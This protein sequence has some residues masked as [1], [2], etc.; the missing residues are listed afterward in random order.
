MSEIILSSQV[1]VSV[2]HDSV[3]KS[4]SYGWHYIGVGKKSWKLRLFNFED[5]EGLRPPKHP[6]KI[7]RVR[8]IAQ[9][10]IRQVWVE[11]GTHGLW[12]VDEYFFF[13]D[14]QSRRLIRIKPY[15]PII[16]NESVLPPHALG[17][18]PDLLSKTITLNNLRAH[19]RLWD[20]QVIFL[21]KLSGSKI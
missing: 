21:E 17:L 2:M 13:K 4:Y 1:P 15:F 16:N 20:D 10:G 18:T 12:V 5:L 7:T 14:A 6:S 11:K 9:V 19:R 3:S 8:G